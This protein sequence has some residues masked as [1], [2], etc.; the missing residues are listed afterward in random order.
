MSNICVIC[1]TKFISSRKAK[2][3]SEQCRGIHRRNKKNSGVEGIDY[4]KCPICEQHVKQIT[5]SHAKRHGFD[6]AQELKERYNMS[7]VSC[8][9]VIES[10][11]GKNNP[12]FQHGGK[13]S[14]FS[15]NFIHGYDENWHKEWAEKHSEFRNENKAL[16]KTNIE[17]WIAECD[18]DVEQAQEQYLKFQ[19]RDKDYFVDK[20]GEEEGVF[21]HRQKIERWIDTIH[22]KSEE[23]I[24]DINCR[25]VR[26]SNTFYSKAEKEL[27]E[28]I[29][30]YY[31][32]ITDQFALPVDNDRYNKQA[33][34]YDMCYENKIIEYHGDFWHSNPSL[35]DSTH[36]CPYTK[37]PQQEIH[38]KDADKKRI[39]NKHGYE[40][41][42]VWEN[43]YKQDKQKVI[44]E[45]LN[46]LNK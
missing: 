10:V 34:L 41:L 27:F 7:K 2:C 45:C 6:T 20:Y 30:I 35:F 44:D 3:C 14:K 32:A 31:P 15:E 36:H 11:S 23:E 25:K 18:G 42:V 46:F 8:S 33:Y 13:F 9:K 4:I 40:V 37:R 22:N 16:F 19:V 43:D 24:L 26:K 12:G 29:K 1:D 39:A 28:A 5:L 17:Y 38:D 21:R